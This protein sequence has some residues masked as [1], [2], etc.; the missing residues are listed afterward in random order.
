ML[1]CEN[2]YET[3]AGRATELPGVNAGWVVENNPKLCVHI[4]MMFG[5]ILVLVIK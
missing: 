5:C 1:V 4:D 2:R 3:P